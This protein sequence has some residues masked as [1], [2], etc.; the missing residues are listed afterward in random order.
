MHRLAQATQTEPTSRSLLRTGRVLTTLVVVFLAF[1][2]VGKVLE[3]APVMEGSAQLG[4]PESAVPAIGVVLLLCTAL[5]AL[6]QTAVLGA[7]LLTGYLGGATAIHVRAGSPTFP[8]VFSV[9]V[10]VLAWCGLYLREPRLYALA[11]W[12]R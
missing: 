11:P 10:G 9:M 6:P 8:I 3:V 12:R 2:A 4:L 1:D 7:I 5:Y